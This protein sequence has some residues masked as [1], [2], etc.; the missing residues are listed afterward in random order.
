LSFH[1][2][3]IVVALILNVLL[4]K[5][6]NGN[7]T[8]EGAFSYWI[9]CNSV[10]DWLHNVLAEA[11]DTFFGVISN[12]WYATSN[13][14]G[15]CRSA[16]SGLVGLLNFASS[17]ATLKKANS[18]IRL[19]GTAMLEDSNGDNF[20]DIIH[21]GVWD[22]SM[23]VTSTETSEDGASVAVT[24]TSAVRGV[25]SA[26]N[27][28]NVETGDGMF[29]TY[30]KTST[31]SKEQLCSYPVIDVSHLVNKGLCDKYASALK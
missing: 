24:T 20:V 8:I 18:N 1:Y 31:D 15:W 5:V 3:R 29:C 4:P 12:D 7:T 6:A 17:F 9:N 2:G 25:W 27:S 30:P 16:V 10:G 14:R 28:Q 22:G 23:T 21:K 13:T 19:S 26:Y 11:D